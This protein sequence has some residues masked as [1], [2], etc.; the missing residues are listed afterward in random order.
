M[1]DLAPACLVPREAAGLPDE[2]SAAAALRTARW[3]QTLLVTPLAVAAIGV[4]L[5]LRFGALPDAFVLAPG[6]TWLWGGAMVVRAFPL[7][8]AERVVA[9]VS[10]AWLPE[11]P[12]LRALLFLPTIVLLGARP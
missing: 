12:A 6:G 7:L 2:A 8:L 4:A 11:A 5:W 1:N 10:P 3:P 9:A